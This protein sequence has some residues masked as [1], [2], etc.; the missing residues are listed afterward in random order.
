MR[1]SVNSDD[2]GYANWLALAGRSV[3]VRLNGELVNGCLTAD[4]DTGFVLLAVKD[5]DGHVLLNE[6]GDDVASRV[7]YGAVTIDLDEANNT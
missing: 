6:A 3:H 5:V 2:A 1:L 4:T 7:M